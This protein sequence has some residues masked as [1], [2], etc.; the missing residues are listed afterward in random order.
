MAKRVIARVRAV[1]RLTGFG[2]LLAWAALE[3]CLCHENRRTINGRARWLQ[4]ICRR[5]L[6]VLGVSVTSDMPKVKRLQSGGLET[7]GMII[8]NHLGYLDILVLGASSP[9]IFVAKREVGGWPVFGWFAR[10]GGTLFVDRSRRGDVA[11]VAGEIEE[12]VS[13]GVCVV[14]FAE[15]TSSDGR[16]VLPFRPA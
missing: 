8:C 15:G 12:V 7:G 9:M 14:V 10:M 4:A 6:R 2:L 3:W 16:E 5:G 13:A 11:R 1:A